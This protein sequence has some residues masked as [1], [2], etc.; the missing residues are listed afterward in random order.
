MS[1]SRLADILGLEEDEE[2]TVKGDNDIVYRIHKGERQYRDP[3]GRW[4]YV[5][6]DNSLTALIND[7]SLIRR[8]PR[9]T[10]EEMTL[11]RLLHKYGRLERFCKGF[12][13][14]PYADTSGNFG[15]ALNIADYLLKPGEAI[16]LDEMFGGDA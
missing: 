9:F 16:D 8:K 1:K 14:M 5:C 10:D 12:N 11:L 13:G 2:Y 6:S 7:P 3:L 15:L 4:C